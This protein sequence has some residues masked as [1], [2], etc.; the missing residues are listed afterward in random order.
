M[1]AS[2]YL[3]S[4]RTIAL[5]AG[6]AAI[7][8]IA[9]PAA[10]FYP[11]Y[12]FN[13]PESAGGGGGGT[14]GSSSNKATSSSSGMMSSSSGM[15]GA[16]SSS[17]G[18]GMLCGGMPNHTCVT[19]APG[20]WTG[21][22]AL[23]DGPG[24]NDPGCPPDFTQDSYTGDGGI[25][26][27]AIMC[28][29]CTC[30]TPT[31]QT[32]NIGPVGQAKGLFI[33]NNTCAAIGMMA[34]CG[35]FRDVV[36][37]GTCF[38]Q[39]PLPAG[40]AICSDPVNGQC[41]GGVEPCN[42][43]VRVD[44]A[45]AT[46][47]TCAASMQS[48]TKPPATWTTFGHACGYQGVTTGCNVGQVC[49]PGTNAPYQPGVCISKP[50]DNMCPQTFP[51]KHVYYDMMVDTRDC[52]ACK[53]GPVTGATC[54]ATVDLYSDAACNTKIAS[55]P[56]GTCGDLSGNPAVSGRKATPQFTGSCAADATGG[57]PTGSVTGQN[58]VTYCCR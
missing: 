52:T 3:P 24:V 45:T 30:A 47:G 10:C 22:F 44:P 8:A 32:C 25:N 7:G 41:L 27:P 46:G 58:A 42:V 19:A 43:G 28:S 37:N 57:Q 53:C 4:A 11:S 13:E 31:G 9:A 29:Q 20:G 16:T 26:A 21:Y 15:G 6:L 36:A 48:P 5:F 51:N 17:S 50:G 35:Y 23:Y 34:S 55:I 38:V 14:P 39:L 12:T 56:A 2:S 18:T 40:S 33:S 54:T 1:R 49:L